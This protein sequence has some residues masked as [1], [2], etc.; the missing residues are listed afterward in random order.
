MLCSISRLFWTD[1]QTTGLQSIN[2]NTGKDV[3]QSFKGFQKP[4]GM[5]LF[6]TKF[7]HGKSQTYDYLFGR[8]VMEYICCTEKRKNVCCNDCCPGSCPSSGME[9]IY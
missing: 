1:W 5:I 2:K 4:K 7:R 9:Y 3:R 6:F 8:V